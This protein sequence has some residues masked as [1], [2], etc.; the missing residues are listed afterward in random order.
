[1]RTERRSG[2]PEHKIPARRPSRH[3]SALPTLR[4]TKMCTPLP[5]AKAPCPGTT[6]PRLRH[7]RLRSTHTGHT[8]V[9]H[10][11]AQSS[12]LAVPIQE[13]SPRQQDRPCP[14]A[15][16]RV[17]FPRITAAGQPRC[18]KITAHR[19][20]SPPSDSS[21]ARLTILCIHHGP[22]S[23]TPRAFR[24]HHPFSDQP[25]PAPCHPGAQNSRLASSLGTHEPRMVEE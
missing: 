25:R 14:Y 7:N 24:L 16:T 20:H 11:G 5:T 12:R 18:T 6:P 13:S 19:C 17:S 8:P 3:S 2:N 22:H 23:Q 10:P 1:M 21:T 15:L 9:T 4:L